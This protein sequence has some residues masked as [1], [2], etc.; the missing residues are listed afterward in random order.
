MTPSTDAK[1]RTIALW[2]VIATLAYN[3]V[4]AGAALWSGFEAGSIALVGFGLDSVIEAV[5][6]SALLWRL[7]HGMRGASQELL[8]ELDDRVLKIVGATFIALAVYIVAQAGW[9]LWTQ[10]QPEESAVG[11]IIAV[12]SV[13]I[14]PLVAWGKIRAARKLE[15]RALEA[16]AKETLACAW[17]SVALLIGLAANAALGWWWAD[18]L[19]ALVMVPWI[20]R[21][22]LEGLEGE[23]CCG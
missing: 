9:S 16:E 21:E 18:P 15:S 1:T 13:I 6:A 12:A 20:V 3:L 8:S 2:L 23:D 11:I 4:E 10:A 17:L 22:G 14:M 7:W 19:A 5:A